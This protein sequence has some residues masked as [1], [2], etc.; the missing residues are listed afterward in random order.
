[1]GVAM[2]NSNR[3]EDEWV[4]WEYDVGDDDYVN[5]LFVHLWQ[6]AWLNP[7]DPVEGTA[8]WNE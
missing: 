6:N 3:L 2:M 5:D 7:H 1:M 8:S 4:E